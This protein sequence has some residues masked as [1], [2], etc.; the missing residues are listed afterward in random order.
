MNNFMVKLGE[1]S[2]GRIIE[3]PDLIIFGAGIMMLILIVSL[4]N[5]NK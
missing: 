3:V 4:A 2:N 1:T 5:K